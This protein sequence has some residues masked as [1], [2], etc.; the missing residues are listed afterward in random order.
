MEGSNYIIFLIRT[1]E[2]FHIYNVEG[3]NSMFQEIDVSHYVTAM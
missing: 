1:Q 3:I 2:T